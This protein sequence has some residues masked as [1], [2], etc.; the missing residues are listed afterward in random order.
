MQSKSD[1]EN[2]LD[3][4]SHAIPPTNMYSEPWWRTGYNLISPV[5]T[6]G[7]VSNSSS[8]ECRNGGSESNEGQS[9]S[10]GGLNE[11]DDDAN[12]ESRNAT[13]S[14]SGASYNENS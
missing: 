10:N 1:S 4:A 2:Q 13:S 7:N 3:P 8:L 11:D 12:K 9:P 5:M 6:G 14:R